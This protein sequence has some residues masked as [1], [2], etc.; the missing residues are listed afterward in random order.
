[1]DH[2]TPFVSWEEHMA[3]SAVI[4]LA[5]APPKRHRDADFDGDGDNDVKMKEC[6]VARTGAAEGIVPQL[7]QAPPTAMTATAMTT[8]PSTQQQNNPM[9]RVLKPAPFFFYKD[10]SEEEDP[11]PL[12]PLTAPGRVPNFCSKMHAILSRA[13]LKGIVTWLPHGRSWRVLKPREFEIKVLPRYFEHGKFSSFVRQANGWG[14]RRITQG[15]DRNSYYHEKFLRGL[16]YISKDMKRPGVSEKKTASPE[17]EPNLLEISK[18]HPVPEKID[19]DESVLLQ[20][21]LQGGLRAR[22][23]IF[24]GTAGI[25]VAL[26]PLTAAH[27]PRKLETMPA[28]AVAPQT[29]TP[30]TGGGYLA[31]RDRAL[32]ESYQ[33]AFSASGEQWRMLATQGPAA[34]SFANLNSSTPHGSLPHQSFLGRAPPSTSAAAAAASM[35]DTGN[36]TSAVASVASYQ[37]NSQLQALAA[38]NQLSRPYPSAA[39]H[40]M[41]ASATPITDA[42]N[43]TAASQFAAGFAAATAFSNHQFRNML[44]NLTQQQ[45]QQQQGGNNNVYSQPPRFA[46]NRFGGYR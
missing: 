9:I 24:A 21:T 8:T 43:S 7:K 44:D 27:L 45:Q 34:A 16:P 28:A 4:S 39:A 6:K 35:M 17:H 31:A 40:R 10:F 36:A 30:S 25:G 41:P 23:P 32:L 26:S 19:E 33:Q 22:V 46:D 1:M 5:N 11:D 2:Q 3:A 14:F 37:R 15:A 29:Q 12:T 20:C 13:E 18:F 38:V 42:L